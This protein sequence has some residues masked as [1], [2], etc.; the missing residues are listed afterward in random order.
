ML[1]DRL[2][3]AA[4]AKNFA[5]VST[6]LPNGHIHSAVMW[7]HADDE[8][9]YVNTETA[10]QK[11]KN[12]THD[13]HVNVSIWLAGDR[14]AS[15]EVRGTVVDLITG[16]EGRAHIEELSHKYIGRD[17][18]NPIASERVKIKIAPEKVVYPPG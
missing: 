5:M 13:D 9:L 4:Q 16:D 11:Y 3:E 6:K 17:Y 12:L 8:F 2:K 14:P 7:L 18:P 10:R 1:D 15:I